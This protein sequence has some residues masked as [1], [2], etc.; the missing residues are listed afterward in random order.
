[1][2]LPL[3]KERFQ[4]FWN[5]ERQAY[6]DPRGQ[7]LVHVI[8]EFDVDRYLCSYRHRRQRHPYRYYEA[9]V[10]DNDGSVILKN[11]IHDILFYVQN[12]CFVTK[13]DFI[14]RGTRYINEAYLGENYYHVK[15]QGFDVTTGKQLW[16][17][18][19]DS[20]YEFDRT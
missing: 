13:S 11:P 19:G 14:N 16:G 1:M 2:L 6:S 9:T 4:G 5:N 17:L 12:G 18:E 3:F 8:H 7:A 20:F 15:D 10:H